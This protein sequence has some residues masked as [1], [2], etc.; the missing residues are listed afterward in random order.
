[1]TSLPTKIHE[2]AYLAM[3][4]GKNVFITG[5]GGTGKTVLLN[6][7][8][9]E[10]KDRIKQKKLAVTST[11]GSSAILINGTTLHSFAGIGLGDE[12]VD[13]LIKRIQ[14]NHFKKMIWQK[15]ETLIIDEISMLNPILFDKL[16]T[17][18]QV[19][20]SKPLDAFGGIQLILSG[21]F[22]QL[23]AVKSQKF[24][25]E[26]DAWDN[27]IDNV[28][29]LKK[30]LRQDDPVFQECLNEIRIGKCSQKTEEILKKCIGKKI[31]NRFGI[32]P[33][34]L[35]SHNAAVKKIND[36]YLDKLIKNGAK[37]K[38]YKWSEVKIKRRPNASDKVIQFA[39]DR[40]K[41]DVPC[42]ETL[43][44]AIGCQ[45]ILTTNLDVR[46]K[47][48]NGSRGIITRLDS[49][50]LVRFMNGIQIEIKPNKW[51][52]DVDDFQA[53]IEQIPLKVSRALSIH[54]SQGMTISCVKTD[55]GSTI[56]EYGQA[57]VV[58]SRVQTLEGLSLEDFEPSSIR[59]HPNV[60]KFYES[61]D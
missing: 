41:K 60:I 39:I 27:A 35:Y 37:T 7:Y 21:D 19:I 2:D 42:E 55:I 33:T 25:F 13:V 9:N 50:P 46:N 26:S 8:I 17:I 43:N 29:Y 30:I 1:M 59:A 6:K 32:K 23:P 36:Q 54:K 47:L 49:N 58:L 18:A 22:C 48:V 5:A 38:Q 40:L 4:T 11:T 3:K 12:E 20:R 10:N 57:Y 28:F 53:G 51:T 14:G 56:F 45:V 24:C 16:N 44:L 52:F 61:L 15:V 31:D 34:K